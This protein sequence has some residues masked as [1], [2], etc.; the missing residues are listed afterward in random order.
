MPLRLT[1]FTSVVWAG[2]QELGM[3]TLIFSNEEIE[4]AME[5]VKSLEELSLMI[6]NVCKR[7][8]CWV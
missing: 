4:D 6:K 5:I 2:T 1:V 7:T 3:K 8:K